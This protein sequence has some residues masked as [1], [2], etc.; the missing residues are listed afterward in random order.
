MPTPKRCRPLSQKCDDPLPQSTRR[1]RFCQKQTTAN[2]QPIVTPCAA[3]TPPILPSALVPIRAVLFRTRTCLRQRRTGHSGL[4]GAARPAA[5]RCRPQAP[6]AVLGRQRALRG[7]EP[8]RCTFPRIAAGLPRA[9]RRRLPLE[10]WCPTQVQQTPRQTSEERKSPRP[11]IASPNPA[12]VQ[13]N[14]T[15]KPV[16]H[17]LRVPPRTSTAQLRATPS[18]ATCS[19]RGAFFAS[20]QARLLDR[21]R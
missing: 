13:L 20:V 12:P 7:C 11:A 3:F 4:C 21:L 10:P 6:A 8:P 14:P 15:L 19:Q 18:E 9:T 16:H 2:K 5:S 17:R 1:K